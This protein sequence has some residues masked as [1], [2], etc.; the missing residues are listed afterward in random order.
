MLVLHKLNLSVL[1]AL[2]MVSHKVVDALKQGGYSSGII[3]PLGDK[4]L[5]RQNLNQVNKAITGFPGE[6]LRL[7]R[8]VG[9]DSN[10]RLVNGLE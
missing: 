8:N 2:V 7:K 5:L 4:F 3:F 9:D 1:I 10:D 6:I